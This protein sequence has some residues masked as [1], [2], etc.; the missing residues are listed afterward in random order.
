MSLNSKRKKRVGRGIGSGKGKTCGKG[1]KG[2]CSRSG[3]SLKAFEGGQM[4]LMRRLP[5]RGFVSKKDYISIVNFVDVQRLVNRGLV[6]ANDSLDIDKLKRYGLVR[7]SSRS[8][9]LLAKGELAVP[10]HFRVNAISRSA[11]SFLSKIKATVE[12][13]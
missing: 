12:I 8:V 4:T 11:S 2:Q 6:S 10:L 3:V 1:H 13:V 9:K 5:K 7:I